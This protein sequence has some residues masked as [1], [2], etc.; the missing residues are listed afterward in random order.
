MKKFSIS[1]LVVV[2]FCYVTSAKDV[3][4]DDVDGKS[5][6]D[7]RA[8][9][10]EDDVNTRFFNLDLN[11]FGQQVAAGALGSVLGNA[12]TALAG[13][14]LNN[15]NNRG[16]RSLLMH[17][18]EKR[19]AQEIQEK[20][21]NS[22]D[23]E[24][25]SR[26]ICPQDF[27]P[28]NN[29]NNHGSY[30][31]RCNCRDYECQRQCRKCSYSSGGSHGHSSNTHNS[32]STSCRSC[33]CSSYSCRNKCSK[34]SSNNNNYGSNNNNSGSTSC[35]SCSCSSYSC[36]SKCS[37]C[38][39]SSNNNYGNSGSNWSSWSSG[40]NYGN[41]GWRNKGTSVRSEGA[42]SVAD[43]GNDGAVIF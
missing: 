16:K 40:S 15:C 20:T 36:R 31:D 28:G 43:S 4:F 17:A 9:D 32:G 19:D 25:G 13:N 11:T 27:F 41:N 2:I 1:T 21:G 30:C 5:S 7:R 23:P 34:C 26:I 3:N 35:Y 12:G 39:S 37:K 24:V 33:S 42:E 10:L 38:S 6:S 18:I 8:G 14:Y 22:D 29:N